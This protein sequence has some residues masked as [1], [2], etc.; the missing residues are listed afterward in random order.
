VDRHRQR[1]RGDDGLR[2]DVF[3][4]TSSSGDATR[5]TVGI[6]QEVANIDLSLIPGRAASVSGTA[7]DSHRQ[8]LVGRNVSL[9]Q[10]FRGRTA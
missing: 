8:P 9:G 2:A 5:I 1:R 6:G 4:W 10:E 3:S 7:L